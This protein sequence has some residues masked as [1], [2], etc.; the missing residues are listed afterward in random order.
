M[1]VLVRAAE[2]V[3]TSINAVR[4]WLYR[5]HILRART[6]PRPVVSIGNI[7]VGG[8]GKTPAVIALANE[9]AHRGAKAAVLTRGYGRAE[10]STGGVVTSADAARFGDEPVLIK[11]RTVNTDVIV[12]AN[13][14][15]NAI[16][17]LGSYYCDVFILDDGFQH[18][19]LHR[20]LDIVIDVP[21]ATFH[22]EKRSALA[23][24]VIVVPRRIKLAIPDAL[25]GKRVLAFAGLANPQQFFDSLRSAGIDVCETIAFPDHHCYT[26]HDLQRVDDAAA[27]AAARAIVT[28]EKDAVKIDRDDII[29]VPADF[30][31]DADVI[32]RV[33]ALV[34]K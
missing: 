15:H 27:T 25:R 17:Y 3:Y 9:L 23:D 7:V 24:A 4:R 26:P 8:A 11:K 29:A 33:A 6:L 28:T 19:Q 14:Y 13:R 21:D 20:D 32:D 12:G 34:G 2:T 16:S 22:R 10:R 30:V 31:F 5:K 18:L 1:T